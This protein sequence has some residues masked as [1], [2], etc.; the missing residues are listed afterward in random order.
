MT[1]TITV[2]LKDAD[3][4]DSVREGDDMSLAINVR[5]LDLVTENGDGTYMAARTSSI[6]VETATI[7]GEVNSVAIADNATVDFTAEVES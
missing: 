1:A 7:T 3:G 4:N 6:T 2:R 5:K